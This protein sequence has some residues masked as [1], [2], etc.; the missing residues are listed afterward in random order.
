MLRGQGLPAS[1]C[2]QDIVYIQCG[3]QAFILEQSI[4]LLGDLGKY[5]RWET[6]GIA[7]AMQLV[8][9]AKQP[10]EPGSGAAKLQPGSWIELR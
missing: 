10:F 1:V 3:H 6:G 7:P 9:P 8:T 4:P 2:P 5:L